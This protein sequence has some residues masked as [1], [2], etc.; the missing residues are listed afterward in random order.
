M[1][2]RTQRFL[3]AHPRDAAGDIDALA[4]C[5]ERLAECARA[6]TACADACLGEIDV[7]D[8]VTAIRRALD[9]A[10]VCAMA[11]RVL[12][13]RTEADPEVDRSVLEACLLSCKVCALECARHADSQE[14]C[15]LCAE[16]CQAGA[17]ACRRLLA[18]LP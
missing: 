6:C 18:T 5:V 8:V 16:A 10:D 13:R 1:A 9:C 2:S 12:T 4:E 3:R 14:H 15:R 7:R 17:E 11:E